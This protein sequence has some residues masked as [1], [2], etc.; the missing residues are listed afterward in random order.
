MNNANSTKNALKVLSSIYILSNKL[1]L[2][3]IS[4]IESNN[5]V[6]LKMEFQLRIQ[7]VWKR[8]QATLVWIPLQE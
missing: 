2:R 3:I 8:K 5:G 4:Y 1:N 7:K 6:F